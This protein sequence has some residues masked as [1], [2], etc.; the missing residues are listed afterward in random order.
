MNRLRAPRDPSPRQSESFTGR[1]RVTLTPGHSLMDWIRLGRAHG[2]LSGVGS[3]KI[4]VTAGDLAVH[5]TQKDL[6]MALRGK[7]YNITPYL[8]YHPGGVDELMR[9]AG[10]DGTDLFDEIHNWVNLESMLEKCLIGNLI[11]DST[12]KAPGIK[13]V[14]SKS[15]GSNSIANM[16]PMG[17]PPTFDWKQNTN[18]VILVIS[19]K[20]N[21]MRH[22]LVIV[23]SMKNELLIEVFVRENTFSIHMKPSLPILNDCKVKVTSLGTVEVIL[24]KEEANRHWDSLGT[25]L[26]QHEAFLRTKN[27]ECR[28]RTWTVVSNTMVTHDTRLMRFKGPPECRMVV[29][30]GYHIHIKTEISGMEIARSYTAV[31]PSLIRPHLDLGLIHGKAI[32]LMIKVYKGGVIS[33]WITTLKSGDK[34]QLSNFDGNFEQSRLEKT[35]HLVMFAAGTGFTS[36]V[37]LIIYSLYNLSSSNFPVK[38]VFYNKT[39]KDILWADQLEELAKTFSRFSV[40]HVLSQET[41]PSWKGLRGKVSM[42]HVKEFVPTLQE[43]PNPLFCICGQWA[44]NDAVESFAKLN[45]LKD[46]HIYVFA[47]TL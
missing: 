25:P 6:W 42:E 13:N 22:D 28:Y 34:V 8:E 18:E 38:L 46:D 39:Q 27:I 1:K 35:S 16:K 3:S 43:T 9:A 33:P 11:P 23:D 5:N 4:N 17:A 29:P 24:L 47:Q 2:D 45:G 12:S 36:M 19:T 7:V 15:L 21:E 20:W 30:I 37:Q 31:S 44:Y 40:T 32:Y 14:R 41:D 26:R 10:K